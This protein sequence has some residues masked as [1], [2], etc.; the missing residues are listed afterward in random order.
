MRLQ[1][2][3]K[4][5]EQRLLEALPAGRCS[6]SSAV[7]WQYGS[8]R[9]IVQNT[10]GRPSWR[11]CTLQSKLMYPQVP[12]RSLHAAA[13]LAWTCLMGI[14]S[15]GKRKFRPAELGG[16]FAQPAPSGRIGRK[17]FR[18]AV[19]GEIQMWPFYAFKMLIAL[20]IGHA[21]F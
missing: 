6:L 19:R 20:P 12:S 5:L 17:C 8:A 2:I 15:G 7:C 21:M 13:S 1:R 16:N 4:L 3:S 11:V 9:S 10:H 18:P 14:V